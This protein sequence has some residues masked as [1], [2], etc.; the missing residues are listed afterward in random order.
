MTVVAGENDERHGK[1]LYLKSPENLELII[2]QGGT[3]KSVS[4]NECC[5]EGMS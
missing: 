4:N 3:D 5:R 2:L 1:N